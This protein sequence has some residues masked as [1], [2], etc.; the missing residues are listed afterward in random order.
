[1][2]PI[3]ELKCIELKSI[4]CQDFYNFAN[5]R[6]IVKTCPFHFLRDYYGDSLNVVI[7]ITF[8]E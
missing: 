2:F 8:I 4:K 3:N 5:A 6:D 7:I 1:M